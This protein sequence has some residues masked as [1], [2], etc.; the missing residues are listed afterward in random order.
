VT[1]AELRAAVEHFEAQ[2]QA[3]ADEHDDQSYRRYPYLSGL[4]KGLI[5][6][7]ADDLDRLDRQLQE[8]RRAA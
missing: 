1:G 8:Y 2:A 6:V 7:V 5:S 4:L 3:Y